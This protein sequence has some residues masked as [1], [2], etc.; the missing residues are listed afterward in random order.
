MKD[1]YGNMASIDYLM[2]NNDGT[3]RNMYR[4]SIKDR[5]FTVWHVSVHE[6]EEEAKQEM[7]KHGSDWR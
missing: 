3:Y 2:I 1:A 7:M 6:T 5:K 4:L